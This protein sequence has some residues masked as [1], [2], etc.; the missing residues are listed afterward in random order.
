MAYY[1]KCRQ[2][3]N[4]SS[5]RHR[6]FLLLI[7][8]RYRPLFELSVVLL[9]ALT[10]ININANGQTIKMQLIIGLVRYERTLRVARYSMQIQSSTQLAN[11]SCT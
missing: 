5:A 7:S 6:A 3:A 2:G 4:D 10:L 11:N 8:L 1:Y 9:A